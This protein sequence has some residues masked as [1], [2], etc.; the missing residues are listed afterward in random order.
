[1]TV[2][3]ARDWLAELRAAAEAKDGLGFAGLLREIAKVAPGLRQ[4]ACQIARGFGE[5]GEKWAESFFVEI[6]SPPLQPAQQSTLGVG[7]KA[8]LRQAQVAPKPVDPAAALAEAIKRKAEEKSK[9]EA[10]PEP[11]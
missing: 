10:Q 4:Q 1:M 6:K 3:L 11:G 9:Q 5:D 2:A 7:L 8:K